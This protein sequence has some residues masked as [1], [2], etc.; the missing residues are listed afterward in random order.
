[1]S[2]TTAGTWTEEDFINT[3]RTGTNPAGRELVPEM[4]WMTYRNMTDDELRALWAYIETVPAKEA[5]TR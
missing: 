5:G 3:I 1:M 4:P 2:A